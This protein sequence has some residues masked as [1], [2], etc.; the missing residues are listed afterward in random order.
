MMDKCRDVYAV[1]SVISYLSLCIVNT[2]QIVI[3]Q[4]IMLLLSSQTI[5]ESFVGSPAGDDKMASQLLLLLDK[6]QQ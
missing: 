1:L 3:I 4:R 5:S 6:F 2:Q